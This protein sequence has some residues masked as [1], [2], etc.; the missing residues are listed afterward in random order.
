MPNNAANEKQHGNKN[1]TR[2]IHV[3]FFHNQNVASFAMTR[4]I[5]ITSS[6]VI[7]A[8]PSVSAFFFPTSVTFASASSATNR[9]RRTASETSTFSSQLTSPFIVAFTPVVCVVFDSLVVTVVEVTVVL[10]VTEEEVVEEVVVDS[11]V[12][13]VV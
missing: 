5:I 9:A 4:K 10:D 13:G 3:L 2:K 12:E 1:R 8:L 11:V 6:P 7:P